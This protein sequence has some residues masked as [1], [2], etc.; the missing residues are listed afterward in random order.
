MRINEALIVLKLVL[1]NRSGV[2]LSNPK[3]ELTIEKTDSHV[4]V[5]AENDLP[6]EPKPTWNILNRVAFKEGSWLHRDN[7]LEIIEGAE[8]PECHIRFRSLLPGEQAS[9]E[10]IA[11][12]PEGPG[13]IHIRLRILGGELATPIEQEY[14]IETIGERLSL[15]FEGFRD[16]VTTEQAK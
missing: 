12:L 6:G 16:Y 9:S 13:I 1:V 3:V 2:Q 5:I 15:D 11:V 4:Q 14:A 10:L 8:V 7:K